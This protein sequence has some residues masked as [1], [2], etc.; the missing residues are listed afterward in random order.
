MTRSPGAG[1][2]STCLAC[3]GALHIDWA[4]TELKVTPQRL[5]M[6]CSRC[7]RTWSR[8]AP[9]PPRGDG[10]FWTASRLMC[11]VCSAT[12]SRLYS[13]SEDETA[14]KCDRCGSPSCE[15]VG[16]DDDDGD[17]DGGVGA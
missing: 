9:M 11:R 8:T 5:S 17:D 10:R 7:A 1:K 16:G 13:L 14:I 12:Q 3:N 15:P 4:G 2:T 6:I